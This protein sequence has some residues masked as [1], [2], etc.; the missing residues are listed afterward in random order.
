M[1]S[2]PN[3]AARAHAYTRV[4]ARARA[5]GRHVRA[6]VGVRAWAGVGGRARVGGRGWKGWGIASKRKLGRK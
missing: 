4:L 6:R 1:N 2:E 3:T 5:G